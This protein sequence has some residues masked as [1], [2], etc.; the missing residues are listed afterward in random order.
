MLRDL[1][2][3]DTILL[4]VKARDWEN[5][6]DIAGKMLLDTDAIEPHYIEAMKDTIRQLGPYVVI[7]PGIA[8][9][10]S[11]PVNDVKRICMSLVTLDPPIKFGHPNNDP[12]KIVVALGGVD[13]NSH[14]DALMEIANILSEEE[15][16]TKIIAATT[17][18][19][20]FILFQG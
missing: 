14:M 19:D 16:I 1:L 8:L 15:N 17:V 20:I 6:T 12:V 7:A 9:L 18:E 2:T 11:R 3:K 10:H 5:V 4:N 13:E